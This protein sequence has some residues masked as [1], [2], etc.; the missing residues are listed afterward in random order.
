MTRPGRKNTE[1]NSHFGAL[2]RKA[3]GNR[4]MADLAEKLGVP[5][6]S[7]GD[8]ELGKYAPELPRMIA[9]AKE[10]KIDL[11]KLVKAAG[12]DAEERE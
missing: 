8:W 11:E 6:S 4:T 2:V 5:V 10:L 3:R 12:K 9:L 7:L 1:T